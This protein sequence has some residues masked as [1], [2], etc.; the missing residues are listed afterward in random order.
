[1]HTH[2]KDEPLTRDDL[3][4]LALL[5]LDA[6]AAVGVT[7]EG[8]PGKMHL[9]SL[10][11]GTKEGKLTELHPVAG[12]HEFQLDILAFV[13]ELEE[14]MNSSAA[15]ASAV[16]A[17]SERATLVSVSTGPRYLQEDS[18]DE[19]VEL[20][21]SSDLVVVDR[22]LQRPA[23]VNPRHL[24]GR[25]KLEEM[26]IRAMQLGST[27]IVFDQD[28]SPGQGKRISEATE[29]KVIDRSQLI[30]DIFARRAHSREG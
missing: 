5:R 21:V 10:L 20:A 27:V 16:A 7:P 19:L 3:T 8:M 24:L 18:M 22:I 13:K 14:E 26:V 15:A 11:P 1:V 4:D 2:L 28:L 30:L 17:G 23:K 9:A 25:G 12:F 29:L 6:V